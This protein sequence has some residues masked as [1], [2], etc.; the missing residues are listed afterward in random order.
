MPLSEAASSCE[1]EGYTGLAKVATSCEDEVGP[2]SPAQEVS[3]LSMAAAL[4]RIK[5]RVADAVPHDLVQ[6]LSREVGHTWRE[7]D[8]VSVVITH[9]FL[10]HV[11][12]GNTA[13]AELRRLNDL[14]F[15]DAAYCC[16]GAGSAGGVSQ[17]YGNELPQGPSTSGLRAPKFVSA[18]ALCHGRWFAGQRR[19]PGPA[20]VCVWRPRN[21]I[22]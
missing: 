11:L 15:T 17:G 8:L 3:I 9:L 7:R 1:R 18:P 10:Q 22:H 5:D 21:A 6:R 12:H 13:V 4:A 14:S 20:A 16:R 19:P 2:A